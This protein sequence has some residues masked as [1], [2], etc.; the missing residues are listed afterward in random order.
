V[1]DGVNGLLVEGQDRAAALAQGLADL[2]RSPAQRQRLGA[3]GPA[4]IADFAP[5]RVADQWE[6]LLS[7]IA[8]AE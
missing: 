2:M 6:K 7:R 5:E 1:K 4:S 3:A 8:C